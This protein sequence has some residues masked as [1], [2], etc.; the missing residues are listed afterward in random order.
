MLSIEANKTNSLTMSL[1]ITLPVESTVSPL[2]RDLAVN[3]I[4]EQEDEER[5]D[6]TKK[7]GEKR[8]F[9]SF[10]FEDYT[11]R[12]YHEPILLNDPLRRYQV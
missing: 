2:I 8:I 5:A 6:F 1:L 9:R 3:G 10:S 12:V 11:W 7:T 4:D